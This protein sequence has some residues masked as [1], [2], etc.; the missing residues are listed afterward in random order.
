MPKAIDHELLR[1]LEN[2]SSSI[3]ATSN[4][5]VRLTLDK[6]D[7]AV[8]RMLPVKL[9]GKLPYA[10]IAKHWLGR[11][12]A[13]IVCPRLTSARLGG[14]PDASCPACDFVDDH[15]HDSNATVADRA[16]KARASAG[17]TIFVYVRSTTSRDFRDENANVAHELQLYPSAMD[18]LLAIYKRQLN[19]DIALDDPVHGYDLFVSRNKSGVT[20]TL[21]D[22]RPLFKND[23]DGKQLAAI[24]KTVN[25]KAPQMPELRDIEKFAQKVED[26]CFDSRDDRRGDDRGR[27]RGR[28]DED[29][30]RGRGRG[31]DED[32]GRDDDRGRGRGRGDDEG[33]DDDRGR[34]DEG[35]GR[36]RDDEGRGRG[37]D[38]EGR[39]DDR[40]RDEDRG[41]GRG[42]DEDRGRDNEDRGRGRDSSADEDEI[43]HLDDSTPPRRS[44]VP[45]ARDVDGGEDEQDS[46]A[47]ERKDAVPPKETAPNVGEEPETARVPAPPSRLKQRLAGKL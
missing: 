12:V 13:P 6:G 16:F 42:R 44:H 9:E 11:G 37:R 18:Q 5:F 23:S 34:D 8:I 31:R 26:F 1:E 2:E 36:G 4:R 38:D 35:R 20:I 29:R 41:R 43:P 17:Y 46:V 40:G 45:S 28:D 39:G 10:K 33:R 25:F 19:R 3:H 24:L 27:G 22:Q 47:E 21:D 30:G 32:R 14:D 7:E 15:K